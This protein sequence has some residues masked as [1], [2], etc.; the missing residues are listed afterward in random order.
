M[1]ITLTLNPCVDAGSRV[2]HVVPD[3]KLRCEAPH[4]EAGGGGIN[5]SRAIR[6]LGG[7]TRAVYPSGGLYGK[8]LEQLLAEE[9]V[10]HQAVPIQGLTRENLIVE[11][12]STGQQFRFNMPGPRLSEAEGQACLRAVEPLLGPG[13]YLVA[14][15]S[16]PP[17]VPA[18]FYARAAAMGQRKGARV[19]VDTSGEALRRAAGSGVYLLK[20]NVRELQELTGQEIRNETQLKDAAQRFIAEEQS[21][22]VVISLGAG[23]ALLVSRQG[24]EYFRSPTV[25]IVSKVGAGDSMVAG[26]VLSL[27]RGQGLRPAVQFG[28]AAG[29]AAVMNPRRELCRRQDAEELFARIS[30][31]P[32]GAM[33]VD[34][35]IR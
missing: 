1:I 26:I 4:Y 20:P 21:E 22:V 10:P 25:P 12:E 27:S 3:H 8:M 24:C 31:E 19:I 2:P 16:L 5:V 14:S 7:E 29:A 13:D 32:G 17:G 18:D 9:G 30:A 34:A 35:A 33:D 23:G 6:R 15:G 28:V 11:E